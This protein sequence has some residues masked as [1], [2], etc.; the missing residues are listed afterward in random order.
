MHIIQNLWN[1]LNVSGDADL[2][3]VQLLK[4]FDILLPKIFSV[5]VTQA[6]NSQDREV[7]HEAVKKFATFWKITA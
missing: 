5:V 6:L 4:K 2:L 1:D 7:K 3:I